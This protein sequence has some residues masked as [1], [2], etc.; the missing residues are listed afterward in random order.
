MPADLLGWYVRAWEEAG[1]D[2]FESRPRG[3]F[4]SVRPMD[5]LAAVNRLRSCVAPEGD[6]ALEEVE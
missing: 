2:G 6:W 4:A 3:D 1:L 5:L